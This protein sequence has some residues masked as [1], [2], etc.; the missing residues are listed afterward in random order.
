M[1]YSCCKFKTHKFVNSYIAEKCTSKSSLECIK[2][3]NTLSPPMIMSLRHL[4]S[5]IGSIV[6][7]FLYKNVQTLQGKPLNS[8]EALYLN[9]ELCV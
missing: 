3:R 9:T 5:E 6:S 2:N 8:F 1:L 7:Y 4:R